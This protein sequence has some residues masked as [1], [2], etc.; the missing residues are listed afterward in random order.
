M[1]N[2][3]IGSLRTADPEIRLMQA[4]ILTAIADACGQP[5]D[6]CSP[7]EREANRRRALLW[8]GDAGRDFQAVCMLA[9]FHPESVRKIALEFIE[10][11]KPFPRLNRGGGHTRL[12]PLSSAA[13]AAKAGVSP[14]AVRNVLG[15]D[16]GS[17][18]LKSRVHSAIREITEHEALA[19]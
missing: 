3:A 9:G 8:I 12:N 4:I 6:T 5:T 13:V 7:A 17:P 19:A 1:S 18:E 2:L 10:S 14:S 16:K 11:G 15:A